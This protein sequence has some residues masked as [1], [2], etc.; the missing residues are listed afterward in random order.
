MHAWQLIRLCGI[1]LCTVVRRPS[2]I[3]L[4][5]ASSHA[6]VHL[7]LKG[8]AHVE[9]PECLPGTLTA[10]ATQ[11]NENQEVDVM[12]TLAALDVD[13]VCQVTDNTD[14]EEVDGLCCSADADA[15]GLCN[16][17][18]G[19]QGNSLC[20][21]SD[22]CC[23]DNTRCC[24]GQTLCEGGFCCLGDNCC[25]PF[26]AAPPSDVPAGGAATSQPGTTPAPEQLGPKTGPKPHSGPT[27]HNK[28]SFRQ[29]GFAGYQ[30]DNLSPP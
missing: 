21:A 22:L 27:K 13:C 7:F 4:C 20:C 6:G 3:A 18:C 10:S 25:L 23:G 9:F 12:L 5:L 1:V 26:N 2:L 19:V 29:P 8:D 11:V 30:R 17:L 24:E 14:T 15:P 28:Q 16:E